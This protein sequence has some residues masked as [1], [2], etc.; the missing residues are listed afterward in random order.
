[1]VSSKDLL[2]LLRLIEAL[3]AEKKDLFL[4]YLHFLQDNEDSEE[5]PVSCFPKERE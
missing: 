4:T 5:L 1:M 3:P 2:G